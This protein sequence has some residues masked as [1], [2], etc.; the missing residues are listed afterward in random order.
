MI[1]ILV[2]PSVFKTI[3]RIGIT[4]HDKML[5][6]GT[7]IHLI[8][9]ND[10]FYGI[11]ISPIMIKCSYLVLPMQLRNHYWYYQCYYK[12]IIGYYH[13]HVLFSKGTTIFKYMYGIT[14]IYY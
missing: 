6:F 5:I 14:I 12:N 3:I 2:L 13:V 4:D 1:N 9:D 11:T 8:H 7:T 10:F